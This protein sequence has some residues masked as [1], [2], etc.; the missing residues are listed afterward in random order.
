M[1]AASEA[2]FVDKAAPAPA[3]RPIAYALVILALLTALCAPLFV[4]LMAEDS[5]K[6]RA[7]V[8]SFAGWGPLD[9][10]VE[11]SGQWRMTWLSAPAPGATL[12][13]PV[14]GE[15]RGAR[16]GG[17][18]LPEG[19]VAAYRLVIRDLPPGSY[20]LHVGKIYA[21]SRVALNGRVLSQLGR[22]GHTRETSRY[23]VRAHDI[24]FEADGR[25]LEL[26]IEV[27][28]FHHR[29]NGIEFAPVLGQVDAMARWV[30][31]AWMRSLLLVASLLLLAC[32]GGIVFLFRPQDRTTLHTVFGAL[33]LLPLVGMLAHDNL[34]MIAF[35][36][37]D[38]GWMLSIQFLTTTAALSFVLAYTHAL[39]PRE[40][41][42]WAYWALQGLNGAR[43]L[44][45]AGVA[46]TGDIVALARAS[47]WSV[48]LRTVVFVY[49]LGVVVAACWRRREGA[50]VFLLGLGVLVLSL[51]YTDMV[52]NA[53]V[54]RVLGSNLIPVGVLFLLF[55]QIILL[56]QRWS[57]AI[58]TAEQSN[59]D[60]R[61]LL[62]VNTSI[63][64]E[65]RL[66][67]LLA[68]IV[69]VASAVIHADR[70]SLF[71]HDG[72]TRELW[73]V[74]AEG[75]EARQIRFPSDHGLAGWSFTHAQ[76][77]NLSDAYADPRFNREVDAATGYRTQSVLSVP[78][79][80]RDGRV[81]GVMQALNH[82]G[83][84]GFGA[85]EQERMAAFASQAAV[86]IDNA[87]LFSDVAAERN[88]NEAILRS[89]RSGVVT[90]DADAR[91]AKLNPAA[92]RILE[93][94]IDELEG[95]DVR[96]W[97]AA[98]N[99][100]LLAEIDAVAA[101]GEPRT[102]IDADIRTPAGNLVSANLA[103]VPLLGERGP[104]GILVLVDDISEG[105]RLQSTMRRFMPQKIADEVLA[106][107]D[108]LLFG[109]ACR[110][111][112][113]FAHIRNFGALAETLN[114]R[115]TVNLL[116]E[117]Y[118]ELF[119]A[120]AAHDGVLDKFMGEALMAVYGAPLSTGR[121]PQNAVASA[122][123][124]QA[125][126]GRLNEARAGRGR[127]ALELGIGI[128]T[129]DVVA[130]TL[131][132]MKRTDYTVIGDS[133]NLAARLQQLTRAY[134][135]GVVVCDA[136]AAAVEGRLPLRELDTLRVR[137]R[138][139]PAK[140]FQVLTEAEAA[141]PA[142][143][144]FRRGREMLMRRRWKQAVEAFAAAVDADPS[145]HPSSIMLQRARALARK[146]PAPDWDGVWSAL[147]DAA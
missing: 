75:V 67:A 132:S 18:R 121:D 61:R 99:P 91:T 77:L 39:F 69:S 33:L 58:E 89:M 102:L 127:E 71:L 147:P 97:L 31:L 49:I 112:V 130:G 146:P 17:A 64:S 78:V 42:R 51:A 93:A 35:P 113:L 110:A 139:R 30:G 52:S 27:S 135:V 73:S 126:V 106:R 45:Y 122:L 29:N 81:L 124:M 114:A 32:Y 41:P 109:T 74:V 63:A 1:M 10:P 6:A 36:G 72:K 131:G 100:A 133:V 62:D 129:G 128:A 137:G 59:A 85:A 117:V 82:Q 46:A 55:T 47:Q 95:A 40:S 87:T 105:K 14:P 101:G 48:S 115:Q 92:A 144:P 96:A 12:L 86:A 98:S 108:E 57:L 136:T 66:E 7:G 68:K 119:E 54:P 90:L 28:T 76:P 38:F 141:S 13:M 118:T 4:D 94:P 24:M 22:I 44:L 134:R 8:V 11:L 5:P 83:S 80:A 143:E 34:L 65:M 103:I 104:T 21:A 125:M 37:F 145:D 3:P 53:G 25:P 19:G 138:L 26:R 50:V 70:T 120:V 107:Q 79:V 88:Y 111:S 23:V 123:V 20:H 142:L 43:F 56:A 116:N 60:L 84:R 9:R 15:W 140:V 2:P 16:V